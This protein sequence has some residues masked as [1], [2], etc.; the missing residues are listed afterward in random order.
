[1]DELHPPE[2]R[3][4]ECATLDNG[5]TV[6]TRL[7]ESNAKRQRRTGGFVVSTLAHAALIA[8]AVRATGL[9]AAPAPTVEAVPTIYI[10]TPPPSRP[11]PP[12]PVT[13]RDNS[14]STTM[15]PAPPTVLPVITPDVPDVIPKAGAMDDMIKGMFE[16]RAPVATQAGP[17]PNVADGSPY[18]ENTVEKA[19]IAL[20]GSA[21]PRYPS[22]LQSAGLEGE[23]RTQFV[24]DTLG[25]VEQGSVHVLESTH[26]MFSNSVR[27]ALARARFRPAE[28]GGHKV[29]QLVEQTFTFR[30]TR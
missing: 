9:T 18:T 19:V 24:V 15:V 4:T 16:P 21:Q 14:S 1:M 28:A 23:V 13:H 10:P 7:P 22:M 26:E 20:P 12:S 5:G 30:I 8:L 2:S 3:R 29:R 25:R 17:S 6:F 11:T 27:D